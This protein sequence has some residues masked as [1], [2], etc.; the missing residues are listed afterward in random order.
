MSLFWQFQASTVLS[1]ANGMPTQ[2]SRSIAQ[3]ASYVSIIAHVGSILLALLLVRQNRMVSCE[4][5]ADS[6]AVSLFYHNHI[7]N[8]FS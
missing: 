5:P 3:N 8:A 7:F 6:E 2:P 1:S 4:T